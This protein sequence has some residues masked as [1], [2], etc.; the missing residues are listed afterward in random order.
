MKNKFIC[1]HKNLSA[2]RR[3]YITATDIGVDDIYHQSCRDCGEEWTQ[4][5]LVVIPAPGY[6]I[7]LFYT[8]VAS[9]SIWGITQLLIWIL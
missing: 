1:E 8:V 3:V 7:A 4:Q 2:P 5:G 9:L 6:Q